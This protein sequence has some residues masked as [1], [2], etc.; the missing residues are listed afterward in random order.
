MRERRGALI[1]KVG[2]EGKEINTKEWQV[3]ISEDVLKS[4]E[5]SYY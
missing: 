2:K 5:K 3:K 1:R 4:Y